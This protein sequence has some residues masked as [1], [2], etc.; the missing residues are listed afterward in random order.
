MIMYEMFTIDK[1]NKVDDLFYF[2]SF[3]QENCKTKGC[4][5]ENCS[6]RKCSTEIVC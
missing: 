6:I 4:S 3:S 5:I 1:F 2:R